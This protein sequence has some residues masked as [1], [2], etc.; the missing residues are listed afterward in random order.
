LGLFKRGKFWKTRRF[1][2][3]KFGKEEREELEVLAIR[4]HILYFDIPHI[5]IVVLGFFFNKTWDFVVI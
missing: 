4:N 3:I 2:D 1:L 5:L